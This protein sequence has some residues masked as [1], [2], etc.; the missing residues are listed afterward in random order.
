MEPFVFVIVIVALCLA[1][2]LLEKGMKSKAKSQGAL[3]DTQL[4]EVLSQLSNMEQRMRVVEEIVSS[5]AYDVRQQIN[6][7]DQTTGGKS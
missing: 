2:G 7:L 4:D 3:S 5:S 6:Q 1:A